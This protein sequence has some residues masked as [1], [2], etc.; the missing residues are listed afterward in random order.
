MQSKNLLGSRNGRLT[1][2]GLLYVSEGVPYGFTSV[3]MVTFMRTE[4]ISLEQIGIFVAAL[5]LPWSFKW[6]WAPMIDLIKLHR[7]GGRKAWIMGCLVMMIITLLVTATVDFVEHFQ[8]LLMMVVLNNFFCATQDVAIDSLAVST[9]K[10]DERAAGNGYMFGGQYTGIAAGGGGAVFV[11]GFWG[12]EMALVYISF[13]LFLCLL[14]TLFF[15]KDPFADAAKHKRSENVIKEF[16]QTLKAFLTELYASF[17]KSGRGPKFGL[18]FSML[19]I[20][21]MVL[22][23]AALTTIQV[24]YG[25]TEMQIARLSVF[26]TVA[27]AAGCVIGG[28]LANRFGIRKMLG[29]YYILT[30]LPGLVL[31]AQISSVGLTAVSSDMLHGTIVAHGL[32]YGMCFGAHAAI[33]MGLT[34]PAVAATQFTAFMAMS[35]LAISY[36]NYWQGV[37]AERIDYATVLYVDAAIMILPLMI[38]PFIRTREEEFALATSS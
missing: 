32:L 30:A 4:G 34:N 36:T 10:E 2:F 9:L 3:A 1:T 37:V 31:A 25:L 26:N 33:F 35:N 16:A 21:A 19:P 23:Y 14:F 5:F 11:Y 13:L 27:A 8:L 17:L 22:A 29:I 12:F 20:G 15:V 38:L 18:L 24:D 6:A 28:L 7:F